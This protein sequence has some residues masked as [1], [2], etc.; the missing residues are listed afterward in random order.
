MSAVVEVKLR[1]L[2]RVAGETLPALIVDDARGAALRI[3]S[4]GLREVLG[5][6]FEAIG[7]LRWTYRLLDD[8]EMAKLQ[9][10]EGA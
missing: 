8:D 10:K 9:A 5:V 7:G 3:L 1:A 2:V 4:E 6:E